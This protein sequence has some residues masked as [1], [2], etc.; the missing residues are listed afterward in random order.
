M[1]RESVA[2]WLFENWDGTDGNNRD[3]VVEGVFLLAGVDHP[4]MFE[5]KVLDGNVHGS[6]GARRVG[7][8]ELKPVMFACDPNQEI[9]LCAAM[10]RPE[11][12]ISASQ[13]PNDLFQC[14]AFPR[15]AKFRV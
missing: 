3:L 14:E 13:R 11:V 15:R 8:F 4:E 9:E 5:T 10:G 7:V 12:R 2:T 1:G 6:V